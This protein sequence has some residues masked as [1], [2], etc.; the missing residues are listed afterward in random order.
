MPARCTW[1]YCPNC[2]KYLG[3]TRARTCKRVPSRGAA[4]AGDGECEGA[5]ANNF[6]GVVSF[7]FEVFAVFRRS[8][9]SLRCKMKKERQNAR[10]V[11]IPEVATALNLSARRVQQLA[12]EGLPKKSPGKYDLDECRSFYIR[13][14]QAIV[15]KR[16]V[17]DE[18]GKIFLSEREERLRL[19]RAD[20]DLREI[21]LARE[22]SDLVSIGH[23]ERAFADLV[24]TTTSR[25]MAI[26]PRLAPELVGETSRIMIHARIEK[27]LNEALLALSKR[28]RRAPG[29]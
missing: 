19:L 1:H 21:E 5:P 20:A 24:L 23:V 22:R 10:I 2:Q 12:N 25:I 3:A 9:W 26:A 29:T 7:R 13:Y 6:F 16:S 8:E 27:E 14:L 18:G 11:G 28:E 4:L 17:V 15:E